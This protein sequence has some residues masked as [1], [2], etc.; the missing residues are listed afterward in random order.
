MAPGMANE[1][2]EPGGAPE[3]PVLP[4]LHFHIVLGMIFIP[5]LSAGFGWT[6]AVSDVLN[7]YATRAQRLWSRLLVAL[8]LVD[9][10]IVMGSLWQASNPE[11]FKKLTSM[12][13]F[14]KAQF[15][16]VFEPE[17][18]DAEPVVARLLPDSPAEKAGILS[19]DR[20]VSVDGIEMK[21][22][23]DVVALFA[24]SE[25]GVVRKIV[26]RSDGDDHEID[27]APAARH[28]VGLFE[29]LPGADRSWVPNLLPFLPALLAGA[30][31]WAVG[32]RLFQD[33]GRCWPALLAA[34]VVGEGISTIVARLLE[35][36]LGGASVGTFLIAAGLNVALLGLLSLA[37]RRLVPD[38]RGEAAAEPRRSVVRAYFRGLF[39]GITG[40]IRM[41]F[42][43]LLLDLL[44]FG[45]KGMNNPI[46]QVVEATR[47]GVSGSLLLVVVT[48]L[49][50]PIGE[51]LLF[52]GFLLP[53]LLAQKG[54]VWAVGISAL[55]FALLHPQ[56][57]LY[58]PVVLV[59]GIVLGWARVRTG[60]LLA[61]IL[62]HLTINGVVTATLLLSQ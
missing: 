1:T 9:S 61:P 14:P 11:E 55:V 40:V 58:M 48:V 45:A 10:L 30:I 60:G 50:A 49:L 43:L 39:Y 36:L 62:L 24:R 47:L 35:A 38:P 37:A 3:G 15:G 23:E 42:L 57:G 19:G 29:P 53:R 32:R 7:S 27:V 25:P 18:R 17:Q 12:P 6:L 5:C 4:R 20:I 52:R 2:K 28:R 34:L 22:Q 33:R 26:V 59:Y 56:Y 16:V 21:T 54:P 41:G 31:A 13:A 46:Q 8:V 51:E 44:L